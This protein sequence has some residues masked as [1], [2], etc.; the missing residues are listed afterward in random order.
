MNHDVLTRSLRDFFSSKFLTLSFAPL[1]G[2]AIVL[3]I[4]MFLGIS[5]VISILK[6]EIQNDSYIFFNG[7]SYPILTKIL[8]FAVVHYIIGAFLWFIGGF[9]I[10]VLS[11]VVAVLIVGFLTPTVVKILHARYYSHLPLAKDPVSNSKMIIITIGILL[12]FILLFI[13]CIPFLFIPVVN[14]AIFNI[15]FYYLFH[16]LLIF[17]VT[18]NIFSKL[19]YKKSVESYRWNFMVITFF[20]YLLAL[21]PIFGLFLQL[22][23][24]IYLTHYVFLKIV[25]V[26]ISSF[27]KS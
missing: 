18:S 13:I 24:I 15:P 7:E 17:D 26:Q 3:S 6:N 21:I 14:I 19:S 8:S 16:K 20:F 10:V 27:A 4:V 12:K 11:I 22:F 1:L 25:T 9:L 23:F 2:A 5:E